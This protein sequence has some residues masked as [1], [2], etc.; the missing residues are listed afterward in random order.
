MGR[1][2]LTIVATITLLAG[3]ATTASSAEGLPVPEADVVADITGDRANVE[4]WT[5]GG[6]PEEEPATSDPPAPPE[7]P[8]VPAGSSSPSQAPDATEAVA[9][10]ELD[11]PEPNSEGW[12][13]DPLCAWAQGPP[14]ED[15]ETGQPDAAAPEPIVFTAEDFA[16]LP[17]DPGGLVMQPA[18]DWVLVNIET[19]A[20]TQASE[21][22]ID[23]EVLGTPVQV[24]VIP[25]DYTWDYGDGTVFTTEDPGA[26][27]PH[28][29]V[30]HTY[31]DATD[32]GGPAVMRQ[33]TLST[34]WIGEYS[35]AG[36]PWQPVAGIGITTQTTE[37]FEVRQHDTRL[38]APG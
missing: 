17:I 14:E 30:H 27:Y 23:T 12:S 6:A 21:Q 29:T 37:P 16:S 5:E 2:V 8:T 28:H 36:G 25:F 1:P 3:A 38:T 32:A 10:E 35:V 13:V 24:H 4:G 22:Y 9:T 20:Y 34:R 19:I 33:I 15:E 26:P 31:T 7:P 11:C 18:S